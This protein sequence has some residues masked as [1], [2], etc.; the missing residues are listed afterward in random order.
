MR[1]GSKTRELP[2][3]PKT[4]FLKCIAALNLKLVPTFDD[5]VVG[6]KQGLKRCRSLVRG[7]KTTQNNILTNVIAI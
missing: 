5:V 6:R 3:I 7:K 4:G 1:S 2:W